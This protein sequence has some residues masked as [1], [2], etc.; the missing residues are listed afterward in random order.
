[1]SRTLSTDA[2]QSQ[3]DAQVE[4]YRMMRPGEPPTKEAAQGLFHNLFFS[5]ERY[6][7]S[8]VGR[9]K[10]NRRVGRSREEGPGI[11]Y[12]GKYIKSYLG[13]EEKTIANEGGKLRA[14]SKGKWRFKQEVPRQG[15][16]RGHREKE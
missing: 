8:S 4:I 2:T 10:F 7:I 15:V 11:I 1:M 16:R 6:D 9:M 12:D 5:A 13:Y 3:L 14:E